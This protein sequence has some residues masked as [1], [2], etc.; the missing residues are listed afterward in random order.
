MEYFERVLK[1][2]PDN[3]Q[4]HYQLFLLYTR[5]K[6]A[7]RASAELERFHRLEELEKMVRREE[8]TI[9]KTR[10]AEAEQAEHS[11]TK[12]TAPPNTKLR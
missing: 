12:E 3:T 5:S 4:A 10:R 2:S 7:E 6:Q 1:L 8:S 9:T 11:S